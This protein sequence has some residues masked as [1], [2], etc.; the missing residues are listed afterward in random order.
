MMAF[1]KPDAPNPLAG[2]S[3]QEREIMSRLLRMPPEPQKAAHK[4]ASAK[5]EAQRRR[6]AKERQEPAR[7]T[8]GPST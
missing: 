1:M 6:R 8:H 3:E 4:P 5:G 7:N 2:V